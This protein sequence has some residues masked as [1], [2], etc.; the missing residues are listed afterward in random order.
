[1]EVFY[2][3]AT[4]C[5]L[6]YGITQLLPATRLKWTH[7]ALTPA[8]Q[9]QAGTPFTYPGRMEGW[10]DLVDLIA[11]RPGVEPATFRSQ[12]QRSTN[13]TTKTVIIKCN[14]IYLQS[15]FFDGRQTTISSSHTCVPRH[16]RQAINMSAFY[17]EITM[18][19][20]SDRVV[21]KP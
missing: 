17:G 3:T 1:M 19:W 6:P 5:H 2:G 9:A 12:V 10:V 7:P 20:L 21:Y 4:E 16:K 13:T 8:M 11:P 15:G 14:V 18:H